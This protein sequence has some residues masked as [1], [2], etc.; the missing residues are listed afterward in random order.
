MKIIDIC[1]TALRPFIDLLFP[2]E[3]PVCGK[4]LCA[5]ERHICEPC[6]E[7]LP[8]T[9]FWA[10]A[11][12]PAE[13]RLWHRIG[14]V[15]AAS[16]YFYRYEGGYASLVRGIKYS[17]RTDLG[18]SLGRMLGE[19]MRE[20]GRFDGVQAVVSV[21]LHPFRRWKRGYNQAEIIA[22][23]IAQGLWPDEDSSARVEAHLLRRRR[24]TR[25]QTRLS[26]EQKGR[27][28]RNAF[29]LNAEAASR[30]VAQGVGHLLLVDDVL[31]SGATLEAAAK[32]LMENFLVSVATLG[33]VE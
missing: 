11:E 5:D 15:A 24:Y 30:L 27:N 6:R 4:A 2:R 16:L 26:G 28:V 14:I 10:W 13:E 17:G 31:T 3:C 33:F 20:S 19:Y 29:S 23:G 32:P 12:N 22:R 7:D 18:L 9:R 21:P 8:L 25:T 1:G